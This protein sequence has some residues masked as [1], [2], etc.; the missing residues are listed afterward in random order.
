MPKEYHLLGK[1]LKK[2]NKNSCW[3]AEVIFSL[4]AGGQN[5]SDIGFLV[6]LYEGDSSPF[7]LRSFTIL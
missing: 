5:L 7:C 1:V 6:T 2:Y 4:L 3:K